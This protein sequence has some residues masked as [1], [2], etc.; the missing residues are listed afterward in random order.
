MKTIEKHILRNVRKKMRQLQEEGIPAMGM[1]NLF[2]VTP[3][4]PQELATDAAVSSYREDF[5]RLATVAAEET[6]FYILA[7]LPPLPPPMRATMK[8]FNV[9][10][11]DPI[12]DRERTFENVPRDRIRY[13][14][15]GE[16]TLYYN[17]DYP[18]CEVITEWEVL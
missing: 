9:L 13:N 1:A 4:P 17:S 2:Q 6:G 16:A 3:T 5:E 11:I 10:A 7:N 12:S 8:Y 18:D 15:H 14:E